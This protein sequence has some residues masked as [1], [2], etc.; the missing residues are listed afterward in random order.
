MHTQHNRFMA[1]W[2]LSGTTRVSRYQKKHSPTHT[3]RGHQSSLVC[4][5]HLL[6]SSP[7]HPPCW[8]HVPDS[9]FHDLQV[10]FGLPLGLAPSA[11]YAI[12]FFIQSLSSF[13]STCPYHCSLFCC[14]T[15]IMSYNPSLSLNPL[16]GTLSCSLTPHIYL[17]ILISASCS[18]TSFSF[19]TCN[20]LFR[21]QLLYNLPLTISDISLL[22]SNGTNCLNLFYP[23]WILVSSDKVKKGT[24]LFHYQF[25][26]QN[27]I[28]LNWHINANNHNIYQQQLLLQ[29]PFYGSLD[30]VQ[31]NLGEPVTE[32][33][34][35]HLLDFLVQNE[36]NTGRCTN[37]P[38]RLPPHL[39]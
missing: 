12:H 22:V 27:I 23:I 13:S 14:S 25:R 4:F 9:L 1:L 5:L 2:I 19:L 31:D 21:T 10:F 17:T 34:F 24:W 20:I 33:T 3:Y 37:N 18:A 6:R 7:Q 35:R 26:Q 16:L 39:D 15:K 28:Q 32:D 29:Q 36:D 8:I 11:S 30:F 38:D